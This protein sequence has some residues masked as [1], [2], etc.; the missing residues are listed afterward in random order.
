MDDNME[1]LI[2]IYKGYYGDDYIGAAWDAEKYEFRLSRTE[3]G[4][5]IIDRYNRTEIREAVS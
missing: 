1:M 3:N 5:V 4:K 2:I